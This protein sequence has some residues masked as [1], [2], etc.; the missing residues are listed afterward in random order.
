MYPD[1]F[2][3]SG[4]P[5][6]TLAIMRRIDEEEGDQRTLE[7]S[8]WAGVVAQFGAGILDPTLALPAGTLYKSAT[9]GYAIGRSAMSMALAG[10]AQA[11]LTEGM[12][13]ANQETRTL[14]QST[15]TIATST[16]LSG[17][18]GAGAAGLLSP[19]ERRVMERAWDEARAT[20]SAHTGE[21]GTAF[22]QAAQRATDE[23]STPGS[24]EGL[25]AN[26]NAPGSALAASAGAAATDTR[27]LELSGALGFEKVPMGFL[28][29][30]LRKTLQSSS[31]EARR[32][33]AD[34]FEAPYRFV[35]NEQGIATTEGP[36]VER[37]ARINIDGTKVQVGDEMARQYQLYRFGQEVG[38]A[39]DTWARWTSPQDGKMSWTQF[40]Q[41]I[42]EALMAD[43]RHSDPYIRAAA[44]RVREK[45][46]DPWSQRAEKSLEGFKRGEQAEGEG[47]FPH[48]WNKEKVIAERPA[49][50]DKLTDLYESDQVTKAAAQ[51]RLRGMSDQLTA[52]RDRLAR[53]DLS[54]DAAVAARLEHDQL[55]GRIEEEIAAWDGQSSQEAKA[56]M[57][58]RAE[59]E[60]A[61]TPE[62]RE[63][64]PRLESADDAVDKAVRRILD[65]RRDLDREELRGIARETV[66]RI[67]G[68]PDGRL[69][70]DLDVGHGGARIGHNGGPPLRGSQ[71]ARSFNV[72]NAWAKDWIETDIEQVMSVYLRTMVPDVLLAERHGDA[73]MTEA[74]RRP[75]DR[76]RAR[77]AERGGAARRGT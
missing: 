12:L 11:A 20:M 51:Q 33:A 58:A 67:L 57:K 35:D 36:T 53:G 60:A 10:G 32:A 68:S 6:E 54:E 8:G 61:R 66:D 77:Q 23:L 19:I 39:R 37:L 73:E 56:A 44:Q 7:A 29:S 26:E 65:S 59:R 52:L 14:G 16:I 3:T 55:R 38:M 49:F 27:T 21:D 50:T 28:S 42:S 4:S 5:L 43:G 64:K 13:Q 47:F 25:A 1:R 48:Y 9:G 31:V 34:T 46:F 69:P 70:Y 2:M 30:P 63:A 76:C 18:L 71:N 45:V 24:I 15:T 40:K 22:A 74:F 75:H 17:L 41:G 72:T 62:Q